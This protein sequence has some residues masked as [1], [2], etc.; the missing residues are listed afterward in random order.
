VR[1][2]PSVGPQALALTPGT[3]SPADLLAGIDLG[4]YVQSFAG[5]HSGV[6]PI[7][8]DVSVGVDGLM[9]RNG[10]L[11]E[12]IREATIASTL[13]RLLSGISGVG[14]DLEWQ[15]SGTGAVTLVIDDVTL[16]GR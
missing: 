8:G 9:I 13:L 5:L 14:N 2:A 4:V 11:A 6:N 12:P 1:S 3:T 16:S 7:S 15:P 10:E